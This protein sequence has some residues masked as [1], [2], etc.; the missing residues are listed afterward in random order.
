MKFHVDMENDR[1]FRGVHLSATI[2]NKEYRMGFSFLFVVSTISMMIFTYMPGNRLV[3]FGVKCL[4]AYSQVIVDGIKSNA[5]VDTMTAL[6]VY[7]TWRN[8]LTF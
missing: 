3:I 6:M 2:G 1:M 7:C 5:D 4:I 8:I